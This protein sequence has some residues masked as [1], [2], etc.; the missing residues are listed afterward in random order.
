MGR[1]GGEALL[2]GK[3]GRRR[4]RRGEERASIRRF[5]L[6][7]LL[8]ASCGEAEKARCGEE[9]GIN[10]A[11]SPTS[12]DYCALTACGNR[13]RKTCGR[14]WAAKNPRLGLGVGVVG[15]WRAAASCHARGLAGSLQLGDAT[16]YAGG[17]RPARS[18]AHAPTD[19]RLPTLKNFAKT[20]R[21]T[22]AGSQLLARQDKKLTELLDLLSASK[23][24]QLR[25]LLSE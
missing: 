1:R 14:L 8:I 3:A 19:S 17:E 11:H 15:P 9:R 25:G 16:W 24:N 5:P 13:R 20:A 2:Q 10:C 23:P 21:P 18:P 12:R 7:P 6:L 4:W 22:E